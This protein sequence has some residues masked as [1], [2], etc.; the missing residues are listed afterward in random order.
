MGLTKNVVFGDIV[1]NT[2]AHT[3]TA[4]CFPKMCVF[5]F[6]FVH[7]LAFQDCLGCLM[8]SFLLGNVGNV[9]LAII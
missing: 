4:L 9:G 3:L 1:V 6:S 2:P 7:F 8:T 5:N